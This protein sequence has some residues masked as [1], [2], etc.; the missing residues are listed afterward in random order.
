MFAYLN[1]IYIIRKLTLTVFFVFTPIAALLWAIN[2]KTTAMMIWL[3]E[4]ASNAFMPVAHAL[5][6][7]TVLLLCN[8]NDMSNGS[9]LTILIMLYTV[10][11]IAESI[12][13]SFQSLFSRWAG[14]NEQSTARK[15]MAAA[16]GFGGLMS[17]GRLAKASFG[18]GGSPRSFRVKPPSG[19]QSGNAPVPVSSSSQTRQIG[20]RAMDTSTEPCSV[21]KSYEP[22]A[23]VAP[24]IGDNISPSRGRELQ[25]G[26]S[27]ANQHFQRSVQVERVTKSPAPARYQRSVR[28]GTAAGKVASTVTAGTLGLVGGAVPGGALMAY[29]DARA[30]GAATRV[31]ATAAHMATPA[32]VRNATQRLGGGMASA[33]QTIAQSAS[34]AVN[35]SPVAKGVRQAKQMGQE[36]LKSPKMHQIV[37]TGKAASLAVK[38]GVNPAKAMRTARYMDA[39][40]AG[41]CNLDTARQR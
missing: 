19:S 38:T 29:P 13:N 30:V 5:V 9:W 22:I 26:Y 4:I 2:K 15:A 17:M 8:V 16:M 23:A 27:S 24:T 20:F 10:V 34:S 35:R 28:F 37:E 1:V 25:R 39:K 6:L 40:A 12:R 33:G 32:P 3:G 7:C 41:L 31:A 36:M 18:G 14:V 21:G 11:P